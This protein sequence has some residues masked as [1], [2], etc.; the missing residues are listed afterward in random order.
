VSIQDVFLG[1]APFLIA[2]GVLLALL[3]LAPD[4]ALF[5]PKTMR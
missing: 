3:M 5:I 1:A 4:I 2:T